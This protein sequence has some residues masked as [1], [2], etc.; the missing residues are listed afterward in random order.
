[1][2]NPPEQ[3]N[4]CSSDVQPCGKVA[5]FGTFGRRIEDGFFELNMRARDLIE[6]IRQTGGLCTI[7]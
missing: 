4:S 2:K 1:M 5:S 6:M 7:A 3:K